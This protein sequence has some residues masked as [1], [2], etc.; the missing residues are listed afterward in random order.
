MGNLSLN[1]NGG[2]RYKEI[3]VWG[4]NAETVT[5]PSRY[6]GLA[7]VTGRMRQRSA[8]HTEIRRHWTTKEASNAM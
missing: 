6:S 2:K 1:C 3:R 4:G 5:P 8:A 7:A